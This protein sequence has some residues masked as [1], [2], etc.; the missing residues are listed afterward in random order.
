MAEQKFEQQRISGIFKRR[1]PSHIHLTR[2]F[3]EK[4]NFYREEQEED[5]VLIKMQ[6]VELAQHELLV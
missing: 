5:F 6:L 3:Y 2:T 4:A 1:L